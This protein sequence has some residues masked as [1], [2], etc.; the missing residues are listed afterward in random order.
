VVGDGQY[1][2]LFDNAEDNLTLANFQ[3]FDFEGMDNIR[4]SWSRSCSTSCIGQR[5]RPC[6]RSGDHLQVFVMDEAW[7][8][9]RN[10]TI[11]QYIVEALKTW[12]KKTPRWFSPPS[13]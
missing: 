7:R 3:C 6:P 1:A 2:S 4:R 10:P 13:R 5:L 8:F 9:F 11:K 12:R